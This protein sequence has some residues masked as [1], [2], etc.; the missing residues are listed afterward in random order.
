MNTVQEGKLSG[1]LFGLDDWPNEYLNL[2][3]DLI[4]WC[5]ERKRVTI[6]EVKTIGAEVKGNLWLYHKFSEFM[7][8]NGWESKLYY[9]LSH[10]HEKSSDWLHLS[11]ANASLIFWEDLLKL[12]ASTP[13]TQVFDFKL[14]HYCESPNVDKC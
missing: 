13:L 8:T 4:N 1:E 14:Q 7:N 9:L 10:G 11:R 2:Q 3:P 12:T 5:R 6:I